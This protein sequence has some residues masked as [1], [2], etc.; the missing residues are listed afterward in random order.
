VRRHAKA[1]SARSTSGSK[2]GIDPSARGSLSK[3]GAS[4]DAAGSGARF[5]L[6]G[7]GAFA[8]LLIA[9]AALATPALA[10]Q[11]HPYTGVSFGPDGTGGTESFEA[12][13][14]IAVDRVNGDV[15]VYDAQGEKIYKF[16]SSGAPK[17]FSASGTN[18]ISNVGGGTGGPEYQ[19]ALAPAGAPGGT[20]GDVYLANNGQ[21]VQV[22]APSG[23]Y[24]GEVAQGGET[25]GV[26][27]DP[28]GNFYAGV[29]P[30]KVN[31]YTPDANPPTKANKAT[32][33]LSINLCNLVVDGLGNVYGANYSSSGIFKLEGLADKT[34]VK[35]DASASTIAIDPASNDLY[36]NRKGEVVQYGPSGNRIGGFGAGELSNSFGIGVDAGAAK[37]YVGVGSKTRVYGP[38]A[39]AAAS[40]TAPADA[41]TKI[42]A[43]LNGSVSAAGGPE[44]TCVFQYVT[45]SQF[46]SEGFVGAGEKPCS[47][48]GPFTGS[49][50]TAVSAVVT[51]LSKESE[52]AFRLLAESENGSSAGEAL[53]FSTAGAV[54]VLT[55][56]A[57]GVANESATLNGT[58]NPEGIEPE[59]CSFEYGTGDSYGQTVPCA[60]T[61]AQIGSGNS[62]VPVHATI[63]VTGDSG[64]AYHFRLTGKN[65]LGS[66]AGA[67][68]I[69]K[70]PGPSVL[71][72]ALAEVA[73]TGAVFS[74]IVNPN[75][76]ATTYR[77]EYVSEADYLQ[78]GFA[79]AISAPAGGEAIG[80]GTTDIQVAAEVTGLSP[81]ASY[82][83]RV[84]AEN[85]AG[86]AVGPDLLFMTFA[87]RAGGLPDGRA[88]QQATP[89]DKNG[90]NIQGARNEV[91]AAAD[92]SA[93]AYF[94]LGGIPGGAAGMQSLP[95]FMSSRGAEDWTTQG[96]LPPAELGPRAK[97][98][99]MSEDL[100]HS[101]AS[102]FT[103]RTDTALYDLNTATKQLTTVF[104]QPS[105]RFSANMYHV[106]TSA[107]DSI[108]VFEST[109][110]LAPGADDFE[111][112]VYVWDASSGEFTLGG[113]L[114]NGEAPSEGALAGGYN[115]FGNP[116]D[117]YQG[118]G[119]AHIPQP[120]HVLSTDGS[121]LFFESA[122]DNKLYVRLNPTQA[123]SAMSGG[124]CTEPAK[125]CTIEVSASQRSTPDPEGEKPVLFLSATAS[126]R[127]VYFMSRSE[128]TDDANT[129]GDQSTDL[130]RYDV[131]TGDLLDLAPLAAGKDPEGADVQGLIGTSLDGSYIY[132]A[133]NGALAPGAPAGHG[134][135]ALGGISAGR[136]NVYLWHDGTIE[137]IA[138][139]GSEPVSGEPNDYKS[140]G[141]NWAPNTGAFDNYG[142]KT[143]R[144][145]ADGR[146]M[147]LRS[148]SLGGFDSDG[149]YEL[150]R[151]RVGDGIGC[152]SCLPSRGVPKSDVTLQ[153]IDPGFVAVGTLSGYYTRN[154]SADGNRVFFE[155][156]DKLVA[157]DVNGVKDVYEWEAKGTGSCAGEAENGGCIYLIST[158]TSPVPSYFGDA[159]ASGDDVFFYTAQPLVGQDHD[160]IV[161]IYDA[162]TAGSLPTQNPPPA[163]ICTGESCLPGAA[164]PPAVQTAGTSTFSG[165]GN[166][167]AK[168]QHKKK[169]K[170]K[171]K[172]KKH[173]KKKH[174]KHA[175]REQGSK[176]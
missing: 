33:Q 97:V 103:P 42:T 23:T 77:F 148:R 1:T 153:T 168:K 56:L 169:H 113:V 48:A 35:V 108:A 61:P 146:T 17:N 104:R 120:E 172:H 49:S 75:G 129:G 24:L 41:I 32:G 121:R 150:Y 36:A 163:S 21:A 91:R 90:N 43:T 44:A 4:N 133:A 76:I 134:T 22:Y 66:S 151:Y 6:R 149:R 157:A 13:R 161:D 116:P 51:G 88:Y 145:S 158:G 69:F 160:E 123:Q 140:V 156:E 124:E 46:Q 19:I 11:T 67:D 174:E 65:E 141:L 110:E 53:F 31:R 50:T 89:V 143:G 147:L 82:H 114:N 96:L 137:F 144:V 118:G 57:T 39:P 127:Y 155:T 83:F 98:R 34:P 74:A 73:T 154:M 92:G 171:K 64:I 100:K 55:G 112:N 72:E 27:T 20:A 105:Q 119:V 99:G 102:A 167:V 128:L 131:E 59:E 170:P 29:Y 38:A 117:P 115:W 12:V 9:L 26:A 138:R 162:T 10:V 62:P 8:L 159:S 164:T 3:P 78:S 136:C 28:S 173:H 85:S 135:C 63:A 95:S 132:F 93:V 142:P 175:K 7:G 68:K 52:Y 165:P 139:T 176:R 79:G 122:G 94:V 87:D 101:Y 81:L 16:D 86:V 15:Y 111:P 70:T 18:F 107:D 71:G 126:G 166:P 40:T 152:V 2:P 109:E 58:V 130:Y 5:F 47:P 37:I 60:E 45:R 125:A 30:S 106:A 14:S 84:V 80:A 25:C 54:N